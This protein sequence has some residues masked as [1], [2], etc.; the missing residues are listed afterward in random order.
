MEWNY[1]MGNTPLDD[2]IT[3]LVNKSNKLYSDKSSKYLAS[4]RHAMRKALKRECRY[5]GCHEVISGYLCEKHKVKVY[6]N[7]KSWYQRRKSK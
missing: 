3:K 6:A 1:L 4:I 5:S 2:E 7:H